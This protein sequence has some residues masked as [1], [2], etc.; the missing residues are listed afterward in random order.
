MLLLALSSAQ[1]IR[2][3]GPASFPNAAN[4]AHLE[5]AVKHQIDRHVIFPITGD[6]D[7]MYGTVDV[8]FAVNAEGRLVV[9][10]AESPNAGLRDYVVGR[11]RR[12]QVGENPSGLWHT[13]HVRF[14]FRH[15]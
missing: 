9:L 11:L 14:I 12:V 8:S 3:A 1:A 7:A 15:Q 6:A 5:R 4:D 13:S 2:P 10:S